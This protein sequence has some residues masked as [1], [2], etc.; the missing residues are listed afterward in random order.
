MCFC[1]QR[2]SALTPS[3]KASGMKIGR[4]AKV[5]FLSARNLVRSV[6]RL[7]VPS[8]TPSTSSA[9]KKEMTLLIESGETYSNSKL[10]STD[11]WA[12]RCWIV[13]VIL[14]AEQFVL[15]DLICLLNISVDSKNAFYFHNLTSP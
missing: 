2:E 15:K 14:W 1:P 12:A 8:M 10:M 7:A 9:R 4:R 6:I 11:L 3:R 13:H 5:P